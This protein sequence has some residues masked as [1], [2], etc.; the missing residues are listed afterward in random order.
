LGNQG[1]KLGEQFVIFVRVSRVYSVP[2]RLVCRLIPSWLAALLSVRIP[3][4]FR[5]K[6]AA[7][8]GKDTGLFTPGTVK[9]IARMPISHRARIRLR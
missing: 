4:G 1:A 9:L 7:F 8:A 3:F 5:V 2:I 6:A